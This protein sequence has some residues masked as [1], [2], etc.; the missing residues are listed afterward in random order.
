MF[1]YNIYQ[2]KECEC[3][4]ETETKYYDKLFKNDK[5]SSYNPWNPLPHIINV[6]KHKKACLNKSY[7]SENGRTLSNSMKA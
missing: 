5:D 3:L 4:K 1:P 7:H 2:E 6:G